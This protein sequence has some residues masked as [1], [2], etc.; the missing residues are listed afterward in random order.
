[1]KEMREQWIKEQFSQILKVARR[2]TLWNIAILTDFEEPSIFEFI[3]VSTTEEPSRACEQAVD[4]VIIRTTSTKEGEIIEAVNTSGVI[5][6][7][8]STSRTEVQGRSSPQL[9]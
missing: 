9:E 5:L 2:L 1:M 3:D 8:P 6:E 7:E 4:G